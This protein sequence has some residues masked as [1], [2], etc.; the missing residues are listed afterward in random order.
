MDYGCLNSNLGPLTE[1]IPNIAELIA[2]MQEQAHKIMAPIDVKAMFFMVGWQ[3]EDQEHFA[4]MW[5]GQQ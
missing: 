2:T 4:F 3:E 5:E 1:A